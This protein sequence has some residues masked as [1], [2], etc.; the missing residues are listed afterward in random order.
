[1]LLVVIPGHLASWPASFSLDRFRSY[2][3]LASLS[4]MTASIGSYNEQQTLLDITQGA[5]VPRVDY[6]PQ[7]PPALSVTAAGVVRGWSA[8]VRRARSADASLVPGL[9]AASVPGGGAYAAA[10]ARPGIAAVLAAGRRGRV[11]QMSLGS[12]RSLP[13]RVSGLLA[14]HSLVVVDLEGDATGLGQLADLLAARPPGELVLALEH[15]PPTGPRAVRAPLLLALASAGLASRPTALTTATTR[16]DGLVTATDLGPTILHWLDRPGPS[17]FTGQAIV[18]AAPRSGAWFGSFERRLGVI[19]ARRTTVL[20]AFVAAWAALLAAALV[21]RRSPRASLRL[22]GLAALWAPSAAL[23]GAALEPTAAV[24]IAVVV[25]GAFVLAA[26]TDRLLAWP[27]QAAIPVGTALVL[28][29]IDLARGSP[30]IATSLLGSNPIA[31][32]RFFGVGNEL[33][34]VLPIALFAGLAAALPQRPLLRREIALFACAGGVLTLIV[35]A[36]RLGANVGGV[37]TV[38]GGTAAAVLSLTPGGLSGRR[39][40]L[41]A[42]ALLAA[43]GLV[44]LLDV[45]AGGGA[46]FTREVLHAH[47]LATLLATLGRRLSE[48]WA[49]LF[50]GDVLIAVLICLAGAALALRWRGR[51]LGPA[52][53][54]NAWGACLGGGLAGSLLGSLANDS[55]P[56]VLLV[57]CFT[58][59]CVV[60]YLWGAPAVGP[61]HKARQDSRRFLSDA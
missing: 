53:Q 56:R 5:R 1:V 42:F 35:A 17:Q 9:L 15:P 38:G 7:A 55:G 25:G 13:G 61:E 19:A 8:A 54:A 20:L 49:A 33:S 24:E 60:G 6:S 31:G 40:G 16:T 21:A 34:A 30:L 4:L 51:V 59:L 58:L 39:L 43:L 14:R 26:A 50:T 3:Q 18:A 48:A 28:Y 37:F 41:A 22:G 2:P 23:L 12:S 36:G 46:H 32:S 27:G 45:V 57:G 47:S 52:G 44:S 10:G 11:A 29:T